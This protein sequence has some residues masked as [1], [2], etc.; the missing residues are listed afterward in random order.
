MPNHDCLQELITDQTRMTRTVARTIAENDIF[1]IRQR[2][3][4]DEDH[5]QVIEPL[6]KIILLELGL[7]GILVDEE[8]PTV[9]DT[10]AFYEEIARGDSGIAVALGCTT[11]SLLPILL[12]PY[13]RPDLLRELTEV[14]HRDEIHF[15]CFAMTKMKP[16]I[17]YFTL[18][19]KK[20]TSGLV[21]DGFG[22]SLE[23]FWK[24]MRILLMQ[25]NGSLLRLK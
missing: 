17:S 19:K 9:V 2:I 13:Q 8:A 5:T 14:F 4:D 23:D 21:G 16:A 25:C 6:F 11:W 10:C 12:E 7:Q 15:G 22:K 20:L 3:D 18:L 1:P 24:K